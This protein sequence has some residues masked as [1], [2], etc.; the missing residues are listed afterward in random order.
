ML[1]DRLSREIWTC[2]WYIVLLHA[3]KRYFGN[4]VTVRMVE[5]MVIIKAGLMENNKLYS[6][7][8]KNNTHGCVWVRNMNIGYACRFHAKLVSA[9]VNINVWVAELWAFIKIRS[10]KLFLIHQ[11]TNLKKIPWQWKNVI[12]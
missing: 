1:T 10:L 5:A 3:R 11:L 7:T 6:Y 8:N 2:T 12:A 4:Q 9:S